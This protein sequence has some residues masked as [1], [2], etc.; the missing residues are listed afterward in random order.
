[1][2][3]KSGSRSKSKRS[4]SKKIPKQVKKRSA[5]RNKKAKQNAYQYFFKLVGQMNKKT[6]SE[7]SKK[8]PISYV[9][10]LGHW[11]RLKA[12]YSNGRSKVSKADVRKWVNKHY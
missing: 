6:E 2:P 7:K 1:M 12:K 5:F 11:A 9:R 3:K 8:K 10:A 4:S